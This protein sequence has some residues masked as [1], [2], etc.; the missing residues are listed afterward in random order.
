L[1]NSQQKRQ[2]EATTAPKTTAD[3]TH[4]AAPPATAAPVESL[5][6]AG[7]GILVKPDTTPK[8]PVVAAAYDTVPLVRIARSIRTTNMDSVERAFPNPIPQQTRATLDQ[9]FKGYDVIS[10]GV[11]VHSATQ[12]GSK[13]EM[14]FEIRVNYGQRNTGVGT[15][16]LLKLKAVFE[17]RDTKWVLTSV[18]RRPD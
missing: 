11:L 6:A 15:T 3:T 16:V 2:Q 18:T 12:T 7:R 8:A 9:I 14:P 4:T 1:Y 13:S 17:L 5:P 10:S